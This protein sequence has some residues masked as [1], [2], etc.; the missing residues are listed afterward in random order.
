MSMFFKYK[1]Y[2]ISIKLFT[3]FQPWLLLNLSTNQVI[4]ELV[5]DTN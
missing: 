3:I 5:N 2:S 1:C 4:D